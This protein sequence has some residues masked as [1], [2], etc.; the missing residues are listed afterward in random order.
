[1]KNDELVLSKEF[2]KFI[3]KIKKGE[4]FTL[5]RNGDGERAIM[6]GKSLVA[7]EGWKA[8]NE[9]SKLGLDLLSSLNI[10]NDNFYYAISCPC[11]DKAA[12]FWYKTRIKS[13]NITFA[14]IWVNANFKRF[15]K[16][17][18]TIKRDAILIANY[19]AKGHKIGNLNILKHY[20]IDDDCFSFWETKAS[21][22]IEQ[23]KKDFGDRNDLL[24]VVSAGPMSTPIMVELYK[25]NPN[26]CYV[27]FG[28]AIDI[29]YKENISRAYMDS[30]SSYSKLN[31]KMPA[32]DVKT[33]VTVVLTLYNRP[34]K[35]EEQLNAVE[36]QTLKPTQII[37]F[38]DKLS[39]NN[40][41]KL[42]EH[43]KNRFSNYIKVSE[44]VGVWGR[45]AAGLLADTTYVCFFDDDTIPGSRW[46][47]NCYS[48]MQSKEGLYGGI[49]I[50]SK[51]LSK[52]PY[53]KFV[54]IGWAN[55]IPKRMQVDFAG[56]SWFLKKDWLGAMFINSNKY[57]KFKKVAEDEYLSFALKKYLHI[58]TYIPPHPLNNQELWSSNPEKAWEYG[59]N[60]ERISASEENIKNMQLALKMLKKEGMK[61]LNIFQRFNYK[62]Y[63]LKSKI[64]S[65]IKSMLKSKLKL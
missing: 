22:M 25:N 35:L 26:N 32:P 28:S 24:Y 38:H 20:E 42:P 45:F 47:E 65:K 33:D 41:I 63:M 13:Q 64:K 53:S 10:I 1:M 14:N 23:I 15:K 8:P 36:N 30:K 43:L 27:D 48:E 49:G 19:R 34:D 46:L 58:N 52:Y 56:H 6:Q 7:Q 5:L 11:C 9:L 51:D 60:P 18:P 61:E 44:N 31:C 12:F 54:R 2:D 21:S 3:Q 55:P 62:K 16:V 57:Y 40:E 39:G 50:L 17:F 59:S 37:L 4:N 29:Y